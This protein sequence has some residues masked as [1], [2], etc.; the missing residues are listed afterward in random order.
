MIYLV[1][2]QE[3]DVGMQTIVGIATTKEGAEY[4]AKLLESSTDNELIKY[5]V[6]ERM[7]LEVKNGQIVF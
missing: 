4:H 1:I 7:Y 6:C 2:K 3:F 5:I